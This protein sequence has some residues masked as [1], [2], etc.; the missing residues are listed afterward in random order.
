MTSMTPSPDSSRGL[1]R[2]VIRLLA[3]L[4]D[5]DL[6]SVSW[7]INDHVGRAASAHDLGPYLS[8]TLY[9]R[10][11]DAAADQVAADGIVAWARALG[12]V[13]LERDTNHDG[14]VAWSFTTVFRG[15]EVYVFTNISDAYDEAYP[16]P[17]IDLAAA[18]LPPR[19]DMYVR[20]SNGQ[21]AE[22]MS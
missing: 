2:Q 6:P 16:L 8:G 4:L 14:W 20:R 12:A 5:Y 1:Q 21:L 9:N 3:D 7:D 22:V 11:N 15:V 13:E 17:V 19:A 18:P 10:R